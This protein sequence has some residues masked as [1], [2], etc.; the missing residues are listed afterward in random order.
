M[1]KMLERVIVARNVQM[2]LHLFRD[3]PN[4]SEGGKFH[5]E[6]RVLLFSREQPSL[7][8]L[9]C[10]SDVGNATLQLATA[11]PQEDPS[12]TSVSSA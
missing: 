5:H 7:Q 4:L 11:L 12:T 9:N 10:A 3:D 2:L 1:E 6:R 8:I